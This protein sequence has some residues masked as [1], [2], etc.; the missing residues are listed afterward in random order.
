MGTILILILAILAIVFLVQH[1]LLLV[2]FVISIIVIILLYKVY[3]KK[4]SVEKN[5]TCEEQYKKV[6]EETPIK[7]DV[8]IQETQY[9]TDINELVKNSYSSRNGLKPPEILMLYYARTYKTNKTDF[10]VFWRYEYAVENPQKILNM[11]IDKGFIYIASAKESIKS[12]T[13]IQLKEILKKF[14]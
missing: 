10:P 11:L 8:K 6:I 13:I 4:I 3:D 5:S 2:I 7:Y 12:L 1:P 9:I 14:T